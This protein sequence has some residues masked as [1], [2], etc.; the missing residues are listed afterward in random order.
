MRCA[1]GCLDSGLGGR[2]VFQ[3]DCRLCAV[4]DHF[5]GAQNLNPNQFFGR[6]NVQTDL[7]RE[8]ECAALVF[9]LQQTNVESVH[10]TIIADPH[11]SPFLEIERVNRYQ[12]YLILL[13]DGH[14]CNL[15]DGIKLPLPF[16]LVLEFQPMRDRP[17]FAADATLSG[18]E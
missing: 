12:N 14:R 17:R 6:T 5:L 15:F 10:L 2:E 9:A 1:T 18:L 8:P 11:H 16:G 4:T 13:L 3:D 7:V